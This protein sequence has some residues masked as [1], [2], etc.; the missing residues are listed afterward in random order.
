[1]KASKQA[2]SL[3]LQMN[4]AVA[5]ES[6]ADDELAKTTKSLEIIEESTK[7]KQARLT[8]AE[9]ARSLLDELQTKHS[10]Q[11]ITAEI[12][13]ANWKEIGTTFADIHSPNEFDLRLSGVGLQIVRRSSRELVDVNEM[14][15]GQRA[16][17]ALS[18]FLAMNASLKEGPKVLLFDDPIAHVDDINILSFLDHLRD[19]AMKKTRQIFFATADT[20]LAGLFRH[21]FRFLGENQFREIALVRQD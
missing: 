2:Q 15:T 19:L 20:R 3:L 7:T 14:S 6:E 13:L 12:L 16:A 1:M 5:L 17:Y 8:R 21:K 18:L 9:N 4:T 10:P 11:V